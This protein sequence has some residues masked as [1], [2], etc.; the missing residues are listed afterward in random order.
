[1]SLI[2]QFPEIDSFFKRDKFSQT[3]LDKLLQK[4]KDK[5]VDASIINSANAL[6]KLEL[7]KFDLQKVT[8]SSRVCQPKSKLLNSMPKS[9]SQLAAKLEWRPEHLI[10]LLEQRR[11]H[12]KEDDELTSEEFDLIGEMIKARYKGVIRNKTKSYK[13]KN[14]GKRVKRNAINI[15]YDNSVYGKMA[16]Y[17]VGKIIYIRSK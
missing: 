6:I 11:I 7:L 4:I 2:T 13:V 16:L 14:T 15:T 8:E 12:N 17:G 1:M 5:Y 9:I 10:R 3:D